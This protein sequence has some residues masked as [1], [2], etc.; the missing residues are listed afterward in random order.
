MKT[1]KRRRK[2]NKTDYANRIKLLKSG[3]PRIVF[4]KTN[5]YLLAQYVTSKEAQD[6]VKLNIT[7]KELLK[8]GWPEEF[9]NSLKSIPAAY[10][11]GLLIGATI[12]KNKLEKPI[13]DFGMHRVLHKSK[14]YG[15]LKGLIDAEVDIKCDEKTFPSQESIKGKFLKKDFTE[16]FEEIKLNIT[17]K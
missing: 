12:K 9:K 4:R 6:K 8:Y 10:F 2:E 5:R 16:N 15:F 1:R 17:K 7:S 13:A 11:T 3:S 14:V